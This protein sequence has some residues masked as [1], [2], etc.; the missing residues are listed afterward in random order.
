[1]L[2]L[3]LSVSSIAIALILWLV[4][5]RLDKRFFPSGSYLRQMTLPR[6]K[7]WLRE[8]YI[9]FQ[10][11]PLFKA[12]LRSI[13]QQ[14]SSLYGYDEWLL[15][16]K[17]AQIMWG[18][19]VTLSIVIGFFFLF[20]QDWVSIL[21]LILVL[22]VAESLYTD[23]VIQRGDLLLLTQSIHMFKQI[24]HAYQRHRMVELAMEE[25]LD[26]AGP[27][28][29]PHIQR[30][31]STQIEP[32][33]EKALLEY[34]ENAP[35]R[36]YRLFARLSRLV[37]EYGDPIEQERS[38][39]LQGVSMIISD[40]Q[41]EHLMRKKLDALL[42]GLKMIGVVPILF[43][44]PIEQWA[45][46]FFPNMNE[47]YDS[48]MG[49]IAHLIVFLAVFICHR[50]LGELQWRQPRLHQQARKNRREAWLERLQG[51]N[52]IASLWMNSM[53]RPALHQQLHLLREANEPKSLHYWYRHR[54]LYA[55][56][57][58]VATLAVSILLHSVT[59]QQLRVPDRWLYTDAS[60]SETQVRWTT[61]SESYSQEEESA[62]LQEHKKSAEHYR[63][64]TLGVMSYTKIHAE[65]QRLLQEQIRTEHPEWSGAS[66]RDYTNQ[67]LQLG[68]A[69]NSPFFWWW[70][71]I[72][73]L[74][75]SM[76]GYYFPNML[77]RFKK[78]W[79]LMEMRLEISQFYSLIMLLRSFQKMT[80]EQLLDW[81]ARSSVCIRT[82]LLQ[83]LL[84]WDSG[85]EAALQRLRKE[86][87][88]PDFTRLIDQLELA[89]DKIPM[90]QAFDDAEQNWVYE[91]EMRRQQEEETVQAKAVW[92]QWIGFAPMY[93]IIF[94]YLVMPLMWL[95]MK[96]MT[97][98]FSQIQRL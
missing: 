66:V 72:I 3:L 89:Y 49:W 75:V 10:K 97:D 54:L 39:Y 48:Q 90:K 56:G 96:Q 15:R 12:K 32:D 38:T 19:I 88:L 55:F 44:N 43:A 67:L 60:M 57:A 58:F 63:Q 47:F 61:S 77:L 74:L 17:T 8:S 53:R 9:Q 28:V 41:T 21:M 98:S 18:I 13:R 42:K 35:S 31:Y 22:S 33:G 34:D 85:A 82:P 68:L 87:P 81:M 71:L 20:E 25:A 94:L 26:Q 92:G 4:Y 59:Y 27:A 36:H 80:A 91:Q 69:W 62:Q 95:S 24:R 5:A 37:S 86:V 52:K 79:R 7:R 2:L 46:T 30:L 64:L 45:R 65:Q 23:F 84:D 50:L 83:C 51:M 11:L 73:L 76:A 93:T 16:E 29:R 1:M 78:K 40:M 70:E 6:H 14:I